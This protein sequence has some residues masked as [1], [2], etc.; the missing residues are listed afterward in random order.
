MVLNTNPLGAVSTLDNNPSFI[1]NTKTSTFSNPNPNISPK[2]LTSLSDTPIFSQTNY[3]NIPAFS[4][5]K[6]LNISHLNSK[7]LT[8]NTFTKNAIPDSLE[9]TDRNR[10]GEPLSPSLSTPECAPISKVFNSSDTPISTT[11]A[12]ARTIAISNNSSSLA[13]NPSQADTAANTDL[14]QV[15]ICWGCSKNIES[16]KAIQF[17]DGVWHLDCFKCTSCNKLIDYSSNLLFLANGKPICS[18]CTYSCSLC[19]KSIYDEAIVTAEGTY[20]S[21]CFRCSECKDKIQGKSFAKTNTN[22]IYCVPCYNKRKERKKAA[23]KKQLQ[24][25]K[26]N[27]KNLPKLPTEKSSADSTQKNKVFTQPKSNILDSSE[28]LNTEVEASVPN[29]LSDYWIDYNKDALYDFDD[30]NSRSLD[31]LNTK[32]VLTDKKEKNS[33]SIDPNYNVAFKFSA[34]SIDSNISYKPLKKSS[35]SNNLINNILPKTESNHLINFQINLENT[36]SKKIK[37]IKLLSLLDLRTELKSKYQHIM[38]LELE[39]H[40]LKIATNSSALKPT[41]EPLFIEKKLDNTLDSPQSINKPLIEAV[42]AGL[43]SEKSISKKAE[44][45]LGLNNTHS[46]T[47]FNTLRPVRCDVCNDLIWGL[48]NKELKCKVCGFTCHQ[49]CLGNNIPNCSLYSKYR[50]DSLGS[51]PNS[52]NT[53]G[54][55]MDSNNSPSNAKT[56]DGADDLY[57]QNFNSG[58]LLDENHFKKPLE[59]QINFENSNDGITWIVKAS[60]NFIEKNGLLVEGIYRKSGS[61]TD[62]KAIQS[63]II[64][65]L[66]KSGNLESCKV[67][68]DSVDVCAVTSILKQ[69]FRELPIPLLTFELYQSWVSLFQPSSFDDVQKIKRCREISEKLPSCYKSTLIYLLNH[70]NHV[71]SVSSV[72]LMNIPNL[73]LVFA[74][75][76][77]RLPNLQFNQ[78]MMHMSAINMCITFLINNVK[79]IWPVEKINI[80]IDDQTTA[81]D[82]KPLVKGLNTKIKIN[83]DNESNTDINNNSKN[84]KPHTTNRPL[85]TTKDYK[86]KDRPLFKPSKQTAKQYKAMEVDNITQF[87]F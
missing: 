64:K 15:P 10:S 12:V 68:D 29:V 69:Y 38:S 20:H 17:A 42:S 70:L 66:S 35:N 62:I 43:I 14:D 28:H 34:A 58:K 73:S 23:R 59:E 19:N 27:D 41:L 32:P 60:I 18:E 30:N 40:K 50:K 49:R 74:P 86:K 46:F 51:S 57:T 65:K 71:G 83:S 11:S 13:N 6:P 63:E 3:S 37:A 85:H 87:P 72:N 2:I 81:N 31:K 61:T 53:P 75:N 44:N 39:L 25:S 24:K 4:E 79:K 8:K 36:Y 56:S 78:E 84:L 76:L 80:T 47:T 54:G 67:A 5:P 1:L 52:A 21:E 82:E 45:F 33:S 26:F 48:N 55:L 77:L 22:V 9:I 16:G 7:M